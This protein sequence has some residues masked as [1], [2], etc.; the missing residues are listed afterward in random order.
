MVLKQIEI[1]TQNGGVNAEFIKQ[2]INKI[3][4]LENKEYAIEFI[5]GAIISNKK[6]KD[7]AGK[8]DNK[9]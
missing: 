5:N 9:D 1:A 3:L 4:I 2:Y 6:D 7:N 8:T